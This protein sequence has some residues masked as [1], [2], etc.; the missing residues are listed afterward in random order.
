MD[1][2]HRHL[3]ARRRRWRQRWAPQ[4]TSFLLDPIIL[5]SSLFFLVYCAFLGRPICA[6]LFLLSKPERLLLGIIGPEPNNSIDGIHMHGLSHRPAPGSCAPIR[7]SRSED[8]GRTCWPWPYNLRKS[9]HRTAGRAYTAPI[10]ALLSSAR[11]P[12]S[13]RVLAII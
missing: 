2:P 11:T 13:V 5:R 6:L 10:Y 8:R 9:I 12:R 4:Y 1:R 3:L 7:P